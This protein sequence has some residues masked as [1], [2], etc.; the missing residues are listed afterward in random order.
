L[1]A[2]LPPRTEL[3]GKYVYDLFLVLPFGEVVPA[4]QGHERVADLKQIAPLAPKD[5][6][7]DLRV[8]RMRPES[9]RL[10]RIKLGAFFS[11]ASDEEAAELDALGLPPGLPT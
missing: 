2:E 4:L 6:L 5:G 8:A 10:L 3:E 7:T 11:R 1:R 9:K